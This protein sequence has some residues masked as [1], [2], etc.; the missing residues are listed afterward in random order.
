MTE[1]AFE[2][3]FTSHRTKAESLTYVLGAF[4]IYVSGRSGFRAEFLSP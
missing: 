1:L 3:I 4:C 2:G